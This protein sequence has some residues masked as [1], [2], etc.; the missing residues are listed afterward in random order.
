MSVSVS[1][2]LD[3]EVVETVIVE[4]PSFEKSKIGVTALKSSGYVIVT[5]LLPDSIMVDEIVYSDLATEFTP[6]IPIVTLE[7]LSAVAL[8]FSRIISKLT[9]LVG[10]NSYVT[11][12]IPV[13]NV[14]STR[15]IFDTPMSCA[16]E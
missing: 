16:L 9:E 3:T 4:S 10:H 12:E 2:V 7:T 11:E 14:P 8:K 1:P 6:V 15:T 13:F 5:E